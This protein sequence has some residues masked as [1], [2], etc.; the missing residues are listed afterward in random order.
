VEIDWIPPEY[1]HG[2]GR[3]GLCRGPG[4]AAP[5]A[6]ADLDALAEEGVAQLV[7]LQ[8]DHELA[9]FEPPETLSDRRRE[10]ERRG[11][12]FLHEPIEDFGTP[13]VAQAQ[14][15]VR[16]IITA[17]D[18]GKS[19]VVH[20]WA[21]LGRSGTIA[22]C[23][24]VARGLSAAGAVQMVRWARPGAIQTHLQ[25]AFVVGFANLYQRE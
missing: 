15:L 21:G 5:S 14:R 1:T 3:L 18:Q 4:C 10:V 23:V 25:E 7:C 24:L 9:R 13:S 17:L 11:I 8:Q 22:A 16:Q 12:A 6:E 20:C 19:V 2:S